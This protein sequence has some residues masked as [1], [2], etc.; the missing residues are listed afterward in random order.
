M[1]LTFFNRRNKFAPKLALGKPMWTTRVTK[2]VCYEREYDLFFSSHSFGG[3][4]NIFIIPGVFIDL[5]RKGILASCE[6]LGRTTYSCSFG[7]QF[8]RSYYS[9]S[10]MKTLHTKTESEIDILKP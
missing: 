3:R 9:V 2:D 7:I 10:F 6:S 4:D 5:W 8:W 1:K